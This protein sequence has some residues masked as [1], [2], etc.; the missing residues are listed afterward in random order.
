MGVLS[1]KEEED[2]EGRSERK[3]SRREVFLRVK[4]GLV[5]EVD[6]QHGRERCRLE[7]CSLARVETTEA[8]WGREVRGGAEGWKRFLPCH[9]ALA[10]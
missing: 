5:L 6:M 7:L 9:S 4:Q 2:S 10:A 3:S 1:D 8:A